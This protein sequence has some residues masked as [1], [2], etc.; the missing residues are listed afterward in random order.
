MLTPR[1]RV[2]D[3]IAHRQTDFVPYHVEYTPGAKAAMSKALGTDDLALA[4]GDHVSRYSLRGKWEQVRPGFVRDDFG[5]VWNRTV[6]L[7]IGVPEPILTSHDLGQIEWPAP[8]S[9]G[10]LEGA[11]SFL[12]QCQDAGRFATLGVSLSLFERAWALRGMDQLLMDLLEEPAFVDRLLDRILEHQLSLMQALAHLPWDGV[13]IGDDWGQQHGLIM[14]KSLWKR[15][16]LPRAR[17]MYDFAHR[18]GWIVIIHSCGDI[19]ELLPDLIDAGVQVLNPFQPEVMDLLAIKR[20]YGKDLTFLG[21]MSVQRTLPFGTPQE[22][23]DEAR[24]LLEQIGDGGGFVFAPSHTLTEDVPVE[25]V[26][27]MLDVI[28]GQQSD[29][30]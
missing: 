2:L 11:P 17:Q 29:A 24:R 22:V 10:R 12:R 28:T 18:K 25:N 30:F 5:V 6:D 4:I 14:G 9:H 8:A 16:I 13:W 19:V 3:A 23:R 15:F 27:A 1:Q 21:G 26:L 7:D 20:T